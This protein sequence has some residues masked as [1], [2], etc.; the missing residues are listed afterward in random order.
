METNDYLQGMRDCKD[1]KEHQVGKS[2]DYDEGYGVQYE[3]E[4]LLTEMGL[5]QDLQINS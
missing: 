5:M 2:K 3:A 1:G 4:A